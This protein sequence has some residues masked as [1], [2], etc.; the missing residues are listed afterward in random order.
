VFTI[1]AVCVLLALCFGVAWFHIR[2]ASPA[3]AAAAWLAYPPYEFWIQSR[4]TGECNIRVDLVLIA[5]FLLVVSIL[6]AIS[7]VR[8]RRRGKSTGA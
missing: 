2:G 7:I 3:I 5:P 4:C 8:G 6:A 1:L